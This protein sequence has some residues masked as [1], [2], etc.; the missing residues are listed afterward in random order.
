M[1]IFDIFK[2]APEQPAPTQPA[3]PQ[4]PAPPGNIPTPPVDPTQQ[5]QV[6]GANGV[7]PAVPAQPTES[8][9]PKDNSPLAEFSNLWE[10]NPN[11]DPQATPTQELTPEAVQQAVSKADFT[12]VIT[13]D[14]LA[15]IAAGGE[16]AQQAFASSLN[17]VAK[18]VLTQ[19]TLVNNKL[20]EKAVQTA[21]SA[22]E[23]RIPELLRGQ[24]ASDHLKTANPLFSNP[25]VKP[26]IEATQTQ[27]LQKFPNATAA[28][29]TKMT[30]DYILAMGEA[31]AP[32]QAVNDASG[33][34]TTDWEAFLTAT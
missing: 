21:I 23:A 2:S 5:S 20:T 10:T 29:L 6:T 11:Q 8:Q 7:V 24:A 9:T 26:V 25:A 30:N 19:S 17:A 1:S 12:S 22:A 32:K 33:A 13:Q 27:L 4:Q 14:N 28:E 3:Q 16:E 31:F 34:G 18:Q 15:A